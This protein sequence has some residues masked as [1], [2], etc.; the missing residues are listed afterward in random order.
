M[1]NRLAYQL[2]FFLREFEFYSNKYSSN[3]LNLDS[4]SNYNFSD[5]F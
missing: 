1:Q 4:Y 2:D 3:Y 5:Y